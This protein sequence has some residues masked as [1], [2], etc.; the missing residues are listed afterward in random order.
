[1][2][3]TCCL[4]VLL[5]VVVWTTEG[6]RV[7]S[8]TRES[9]RGRRYSGRKLDGHDSS[10]DRK[11]NHE[12][13]GSYSADEPKKGEFSSS[14]DSP[15]QPGA[16]TTMM[17][18]GMMQAN[19]AKVQGPMNA[20][21]QDSPE[22][23]TEDPTEDD[24]MEEPY[25][26]PETPLE[27]SPDDLTPEFETPPSETGM[28][29]G[30]MNEA[31]M[32]NR[33]M[34]T[35]NNGRM[36]AH[37]GMRQQPKM[38]SNL[39][40]NMVMGN[41]MVAASTSG[42]VM[43]D[44]K[45]AKKSTPAKEAAKTQKLMQM[46]GA[47]QSNP[48]YSEDEI[49]HLADS[50]DEMWPEDEDAA[51]APL[52]G[53]TLELKVCPDGSSVGRTGPDCAFE[54]CPEPE[55]E[56]EPDVVSEDEEG[57]DAPVACTLELKVCPD[58]SSVGRTGPDCAFEAC[59]EAQSLDELATEVPFA[60]TLE[61][62]TCSDGTVVRRR[63]PDCSFEPCPE[64]ASL[65]T[66]PPVALDTE[67]PTQVPAVPE[68]DIPMVACPDDVLQCSDGSWVVREGPDCSFPP[69]PSA[70]ATLA[71]TTAGTLF[72]AE[73]DAPSEIEEED[74]LAPVVCPDDILQCADGSEVVREGPD[75]EFP[76]CPWIESSLPPGTDVDC[77]DDILQCADG[78]EVVRE[79]PDCEFPDC[80]WIEGSLPPGTDV[81][82]AT[83]FPTTAE[84][85]ADDET[86]DQIGEENS[87]APAACPGDI[88]QCADGSELVR[89]G[90]DCEFPDCPWIAGSLPPGTDGTSD[91]QDTG[92]ETDDF[93][94]VVNDNCVNA[95]EL[96]VGDTLQGTT[97][98]ASNDTEADTCGVNVEALLPEPAGFLSLQQLGVWYS[99]E[100]TDTR[101]RA[102]VCAEL[103]DESSVPFIVTV[104]AGGDGCSD[105]TC[106]QVYNTAGCAVDWD[107]SSDFEMY[108]LLVRSLV[109][110][111][112]FLDTDTDLEFE[113]TITEPVPPVN[114]VCEGAIELQIGDTVTSR[115]LSGSSNTDFDGR[116]LG[117]Q[118]DPPNPNV[119]VPG[120][121]YSVVGDGGRLVASTCTEGTESGPT[122]LTVYSGSCE[123]LICETADPCT[124]ELTSTEAGR[125][126]YILVEKVLL[127]NRPGEF[128]LTV[129]N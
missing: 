124:A 20:V 128:E 121:W 108:F 94:L 98:F 110:E 79:G 4:L 73:T 12:N 118:I 38:T 105:L 15:S 23:E 28:M 58:G 1:M 114:D 103:G 64:G 54:P 57:A 16:K 9:L 75:C 119:N 3:K 107:A 33:G 25:Q 35:M 126:Y 104:Y 70:S 90:P 11:K 71:P 101:L 117:A 41:M 74:S 14:D 37:N 109:V 50:F 55:P 99:I 92:N 120:L 86:D 6:R 34:M 29:Q 66:D 87:I 67:V 43:S 84:T 51:D 125:V 82:S 112:A 89:E 61:V 97:A 53:C 59:P 24:Y 63:G 88:L 96:E 122:L 18:M 26:Y 95:I 22:E 46:S 42:K 44:V 40:G 123:N 13:K 80:P 77:P 65:V 8:R 93:F 78:S 81:E 113:L 76:P 127:A 21:D 72:D 2:K 102:S 91:G 85:L 60:C 19:G 68:T 39:K 116:C 111:G 69:C 48:M 62:A 10:N 47:T 32:N 115:I 129:D 36:M 7:A 49:V 56:A 106:A 83:L 52:V 5:A 45:K 27:D 30:N 17:M 31:K 100:A